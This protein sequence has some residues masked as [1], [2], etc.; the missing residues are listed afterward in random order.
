M[1]ALYILWHVAVV[2]TFA[3]RII[4]INKLLRFRLQTFNYEIPY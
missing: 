4:S 3:L 1:I 2:N